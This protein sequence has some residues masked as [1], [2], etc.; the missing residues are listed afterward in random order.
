MRQRRRQDENRARS[1][2]GTSSVPTRLVLFPCER[3]SRVLTAIETAGLEPNNA[4]GF[5]HELRT[6]AARVGLQPRRARRA[7]RIARRPGALAR[8]ATVPTRRTTRVRKRLHLDLPD[9]R[10]PPAG[11]PLH[12]PLRPTAVN[13][14]AAPTTRRRHRRAVSRTSA[15]AGPLNQTAAK[16]GEHPSP[17]IPP[18]PEATVP[19]RSVEMTA[20]DGPQQRSSSDAKMLRLP[21][22]CGARHRSCERLRALSFGQPGGA[23][24]RA[25][26]DGSGCDRR[27]T[28]EP[29]EGLLPA[30]PTTT[31]RFC[32]EASVDLGGPAAWCGAVSAGGR[33]EGCTPRVCRTVDAKG[34]VHPHPTAASAPRRGRQHP[35]RS[36][37]CRRRLL[38]ALADA[39]EEPQ[40]AL[41]GRV[42]GLVDIDGHRFARAGASAR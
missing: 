2:V 42:C 20:S 34:R 19:D 22:E 10:P 23:A 25:R 6:H 11:T 7:R 8:L 29:D 21:G 40:A 18:S 24:T 26:H 38:A 4:E 31:R 39:P 13:R 41:N 27:L 32:C 3:L 14:V 15:H 30:G 33:R 5:R 28:P 16:M 37:R 1:V 12:P 9:R 36:R 17:P 35:P